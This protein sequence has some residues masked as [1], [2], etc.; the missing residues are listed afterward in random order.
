MRALQEFWTRA[1]SLLGRQETSVKRI[2]V[3]WHGDRGQ[4]R[5]AT[6]M[7]TAGEPPGAGEKL[8]LWWGVTEQQ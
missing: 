7:E 6:S 1:S 2:Y 8:E 3:P 4:L 5:T